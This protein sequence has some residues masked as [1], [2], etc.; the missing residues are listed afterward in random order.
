MEPPRP[1]FALLLAGALV[2]HFPR[3]P[4]HQP[5]W[6]NSSASC[7]LSCS[8][9]HAGSIAGAFHVC[10]VPIRV[11]QSP[12]PGH[13][14]PNHAG[15]QTPAQPLLPNTSRFGPTGHSCLIRP[16]RSV[17][18]RRSLVEPQQ[19]PYHHR[20][21]FARRQPAQPEVTKAIASVPM[22]PGASF[23]GWVILRSVDRSV[24][25]DKKQPS[26]PMKTALPMLVFRLVPRPLWKAFRQDQGA[27]SMANFTQ[28]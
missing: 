6:P 20:R 23:A 10:H 5:S 13:D 3:L 12:R 7:R 15:P 22:A 25:E 19:T 2:L 27:R 8:I 14:A 24:T 4:M 16:S 18:R 17:P 28:N 1:L 26:P 21:A 11:S 9:R